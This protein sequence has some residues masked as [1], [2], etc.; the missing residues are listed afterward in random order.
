M[1]SG[2]GGVGFGQNITSSQSSTVQ[3][4]FLPPAL[5]DLKKK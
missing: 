3:R 2:G 4:S 5:A 1:N